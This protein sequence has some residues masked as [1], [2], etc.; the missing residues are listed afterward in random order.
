MVFS[1][2]GPNQSIEWGQ[3]RVSKSHEP[4]ISNQPVTE[5]VKVMLDRLACFVEE[6]TAHCL[7]TKMPAGLS[8][9]EIRLEQ[10]LP[11]VPERFQNTLKDGGTVVWRLTYHQN[12]FE[13]T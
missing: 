6:V 1:K 7:Q 10:R 2:V 9:R 8:I 5:F 13:E 4:Q 3:I 12:T 11:E